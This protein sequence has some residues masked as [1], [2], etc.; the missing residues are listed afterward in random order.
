MNVK[1]IFKKNQIIIV[2]L[3]IMIAVAGYLNFSRDKTKEKE[4]EDAAS[5]AVGDD[6]FANLEG[7]SY[8]DYADISD[9]DDLAS[10]EAINDDLLVVNDPV[11]TEG[12]LV[13]KGKDDAAT[14]GKAEDDKVVDATK[15]DDKKTDDKKTEDKKTDASDKEA[16]KDVET[17]APGEAILAST[18]ISSSYFST[19]KLTREQ[20]RAKNK[21]NLLD[22]I[23]DKNTSQDLKD[24]ASAALL[25]LNS[26]SDKESSTEI[27]LE[28]KGFSGAV[29]SIVEESVDVIVNSPALTDQDMAI[30]E[31]VVMRKTG[32]KAKNIVIT[33]V[34]TED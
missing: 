29:V 5:T 8:S 2:A 6:L 32:A 4:L 30:I 25:E 24:E 28:A 16:A 33:C 3:A 19:A 10:S 31:D 12:N 23:S 9:E 18:T 26:I 14:S 34:V 22:I 17:T 15:N 20:T 7:E 21:A 1:N 27:L 13:S 11:T